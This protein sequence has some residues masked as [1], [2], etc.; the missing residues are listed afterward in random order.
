MGRKKSKLISTGSSWDFKKLEEAYNII[1]DI[2]INKFGFDFYPN[3]IEVISAEQMLDAYSSV[4]MPIMYNHW[5]FGKQFV[6]E[7]EAYKHGNMGL[8]YE[9]VSNTNPTI[10]YLMEENTMCMQM[11]VMAHACV[12]GETE[13][14]S[15]TGWKRISEY[16]E[17]GMVGQYTS[18]GNMEFVKPERY[19]VNQCEEMYEFKNE[20]VHQR[21]TK[22]HRVVYKS[23]END[24]LKVRPFSEIKEMHENK[25][26]GFHGKFI[27]VFNPVIT[28]SLDIS[29]INLR[30]QV[31]IAADGNIISNKVRFHLKKERKLQRLEMLLNEAKIQFTKTDSY[32]GRVFI[33]FD[34]NGLIDKEFDEKYYLASLHQLNII[35]DEVIYWDGSVLGRENC[36][37]FCS[38][39]KKSADF[40]Q[41]CFAATGHR[42]SFSS[43]QDSRE[44][45]KLL[46]I[47][48]KTNDTTSGMSG[49]R[50]KPCEIT[51]FTPND[52]KSYCFTVPSGMLV[53]R[54]QNYIFVTGNCIGHN[55]FF[56]NNY[57]FKQWT[58]ASTILDYL[59]FAKKFISECEEKHGAKEVEQILDS[60]H[61]LMNYGVFKYKR[62]EPLSVEQEKQRQKERMDYQQQ[63]YNELWKTTIPQY[64]KDN[65]QEE[66]RIPAEPEENI[67]FFIEQNAPHLEGWK[68]EIIRIVRNV[69]QYF[70]PQMHTKVSN[71]GTATFV[72][73][74]IMNELY[75]QGYINDG[76]MLE[77]LQSHT[78]V[79]YQP[80]FDSK[81]YSGINPYALGFAIYQDIQRVCMHP[82]DEDKEWFPEF[83]GNGDWLKTIKWAAYNFKDESFIHQFLSPK[84]IRDLKLFSITDNDKESEIEIEA[85]HDFNGYKKVRENLAMQYNI[86]EMMPNIQAYNVN[87]RGDRSLTLR[88][89]QNNRRPLDKEMTAET[90]KH[91]MRLWEYSVKLES[92]DEDGRVTANFSVDKNK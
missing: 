5:S 81:H 40:I 63:I 22:D 65:E 47:V 87:R 79:V 38:T 62:P 76:Y 67:L 74:L 89:F 4:A 73:H 33:K 35:S 57:M 83:A 18:E 9:V 86:S 13:Y 58:D 60:C 82:T 88:H 41:Y 50:N 6:R 1:E 23:H 44:N 56:K 72:H 34:H 91:V 54:C 92:V 45:K 28:S 84:V 69:S 24:N 31:A 17:G 80:S 16:E 32:D 53:L 68:R 48:R 20:R 55:S 85:I 3:Q 30:L 39:S 37:I 11:L 19:I 70:Y 27:N 2:A 10:S 75:N 46:Y 78:S 26:R 51:A 77:F 64:H 36:P 21:L 12:D 52:K 15:P 25:T 61:A 14:L 29:D 8:A 59:S 49:G 42:A 43:Y 71:E 66:Q 90:L 7:S